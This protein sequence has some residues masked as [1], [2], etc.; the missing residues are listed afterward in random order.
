MV[1]R[2]VAA[3]LERLAVALAVAVVVLV[4]RLAVAVA[5][6]LM[7]MVWEDI[8]VLAGM[9]DKMHS[10]QIVVYHLALAMEA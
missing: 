8:M 2:L 6:S 3:V 10:D 4:E 7:V 9:V 5:A 1:E